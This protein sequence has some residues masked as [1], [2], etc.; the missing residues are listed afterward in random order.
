LTAVYL[1]A[2]IL[3]LP[4][5]FLKAFWEHLTLKLLRVPVEDASFLHRNELFGHI[6]HRLI[7][8][9]AKNVVFC[10]LPG[11]LNGIIAVGLLLTSTINLFYFGVGL[12][13]AASGLI[14]IL[15]FV[16][17]L[18]FWVGLSLWCSKYPLY[19]D[20]VQMKEIVYDEKTDIVTKVLLF[21]PT[22]VVY[23]GSFLERYGINVLLAAG[24]T[25]AL[26]VKFPYAFV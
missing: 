15:F 8:S 19:E 2:K 17:I 25:A 9:K 23:A 22:V 12:R 7:T 21:I 26:V 10:L 4:G 11:L 20:I 16:Y 14:N 18:M 24:V 5:A 13:D 1:I 3:T 6:E